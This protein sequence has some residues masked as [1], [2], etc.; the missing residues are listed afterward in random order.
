M[1]E[2]TE[3]SKAVYDYIVNFMMTHNY[4]PPIKTI[5]S[6]MHYGRSTIEYHLRCL[7]KEGQ[8]KIGEYGRISVKG[9]KYVMEGENE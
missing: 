3:Q 7:A 8:I 5:S 2:T 4:T 6:E 1:T 9:M